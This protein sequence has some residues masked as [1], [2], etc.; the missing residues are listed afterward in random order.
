MSGVEKLDLS[1]RDVPLESFRAS[2]Q[3]CHAS[4]WVIVAS[5][6]PAKR[7]LESFTSLKNS[8]SDP[9]TQP[10]AAAAFTIK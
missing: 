6:T 8:W 9:T 2:R 4:P 5:V 10:A 1:L 3:K 7:W